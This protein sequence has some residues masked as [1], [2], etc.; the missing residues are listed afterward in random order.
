MFCLDNDKLWRVKEMAMRE[1]VEREKASAKRKLLSIRGDIDRKARE[2]KQMAEGD[3]YGIAPGLG[4][5]NAALY[6]AMCGTRIKELKEW[7]SML[8][9]ILQEE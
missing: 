7:I 9:W 6:M 2:T 3:A 1:K 4:L 5:S 8:E